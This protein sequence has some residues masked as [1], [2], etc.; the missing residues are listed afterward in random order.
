MLTNILRRIGLARLLRLGVT[1]AVPPLWLEIAVLHFRGSFQSPFMW[2]PILSLPAVLAGGSASTLVADPH[3]SR[4]IFRPLAWLMAAVGALGTFFHL[5][6]VGRQMGGYYN[7]KYN[8][9]TGPPFPAPPQVA[10]LGLLGAI[11]SA[12]RSRRETGTLVRWIRVVNIPS[13]L[14]LAI[15]AGYNHWEGEYFNRVMYTPVILGPLAALVHLA[16]LA[17]VRALRAL[18]APVSAIAAL[19]GLVGFGFHLWNISRRPGG[20]SWQ[21]FFYGP[22][23]AAPLQMTGQGLLGLLATIFGD[24][25]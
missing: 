15:E 13:Y 16:T 18:E 12:S 4:A 17:R 8:L 6:G 10:L 1:V 5:R 9:V 2:I 20:F 23:V 19:A 25:R 14:L 3:R 21:S 7:W 22:P 24:E 11:A